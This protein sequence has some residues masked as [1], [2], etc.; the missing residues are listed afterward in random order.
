MGGGAGQQHGRSPKRRG[1]K[2]PPRRSAPGPTL[3]L[4][5]GA[6][7]PSRQKRGPAPS[8]RGPRGRGALVP[9][10]PQFAPPPGPPEPAPCSPLRMCRVTRRCI[11]FDWAAPGAA[12]AP[13]AGVGPAGRGARE[14]AGGEPR[15]PA[16]AGLAGARDSGRLKKR[17]AFSS[18]GLFSSPLQG[19]GTGRG[20]RRGPHPSHLVWGAFSDAT[21][22]THVAWT[23]PRLPAGRPRG[24]RNDWRGEERQ[25]S[26]FSG[27]PWTA[28]SP[29]TFP[30]PGADPGKYIVV[31]RRRRRLVASQNK[32]LKLLTRYI[33]IAEKYRFT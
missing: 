24:G 21:R 9:H 17:F 5:A 26:G 3:R 28:P 7:G 11:C 13:A 1:K 33:I 32:N 19:R 23:P 20:S 8:G 6:G 12:P 2:S 4:R 10:L 29:A 25:I 27:L 14:R 15:G 16:G 22:F 31:G 18:R 30:R